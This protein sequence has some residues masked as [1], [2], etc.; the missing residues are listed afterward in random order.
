MSGRSTLLATPTPAQE[1]YR[2]WSNRGEWFEASEAL[3][4][5][6]PDFKDIPMFTCAV[7]VD[8]I[9]GFGSFDGATGLPLVEFPHGSRP[10]AEQAARR[11]LKGV[12]RELYEAQVKD[13]LEKREES[14]G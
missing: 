2:R 9:S 13:V 1:V 8:G 6:L 4:L 11:A 5:E 7:R 12:S 14:R 3:L 10:L